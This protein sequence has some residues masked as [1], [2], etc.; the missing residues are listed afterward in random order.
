MGLRVI[1]NRLAV[2]C[3]AAVLCG[4]ETP[5]DPSAS[6]LKGGGGAGVLLATTGF[7]ELVRIDI[8][9]GTA[10]L[11]GS[12]GTI[13]DG[14]T[15]G[16][17]GISFHPN[18]DL[19]VSSNQFFEP[20]DP[21]CG[22][23]GSCA[24]IYEIDPANGAFLDD[25]GITGFAFLSD[26]DFSGETLYANFFDNDPDE[27]PP[28]P[29]GGVLATIDPVSGAATPVVPDTPFGHAGLDRNLLNGAISVHPIT[30]D[31]WVVERSN[32]VAG[33]QHRI[34]R[35]DPSTGEALS[36]TVPLGLDG[37]PAGF[38]F[39]GLEILADG[40]FVGTQARSSSNV[41]L[42]DP[43]PDPTTGFANLT[44][45]PISLPPLV[46]NLN[47]LESVRQDGDCDGSGK[48]SKSDKSSQSDKSDKSGKSNK[49]G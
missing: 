40:R 5:F 34:F 41:Y 11:L 30:C 46:G 43:E 21:G 15:P 25:I 49:S 37:R 35:V 27:A 9:V 33:Q 14:R 38:G 42:I 18:G 17:S 3:L 1:F 31:V 24:S 32:R 7:G 10:E 22:G 39:D 45:I 4:C 2:L 48:S 44:L 36:P 20:T 12:V 8:D 47:G 16:W 6:K 29:L 19:F 13:P 28:E 23:F 26:I